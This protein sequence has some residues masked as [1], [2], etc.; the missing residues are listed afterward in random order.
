MSQKR[1]SLLFQSF[2]EV[3][4]RKPSQQT[5]ET[6][7]HSLLGSTYGKS[8]KLRMLVLLWLDL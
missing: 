5:E 6:Y 1:D 4:R 8:E 7:A 3:R 2:K